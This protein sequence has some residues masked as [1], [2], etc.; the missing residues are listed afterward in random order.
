MWRSPVVAGIGLFVVLLAPM[1]SARAAM[2]DYILG[3]GDK[4]QIKLYEWRSTVG[5]V[6]EWSAL[7][8]DF[9]VGPAGGLSLPLIGDVQAAGLTTDQL[10]KSVAGEL[11]KAV[12]LA[13]PPTPSVQIV[14][15]RPFY[16]VG[17]VMRPGSYPFQPAMT[18]LQ[19]VSIA[20]GL[21]RPSDD[22]RYALTDVGDV[23]TLQAEYNRLVARRARLKAELDGNDKITFPS[24]FL[25]SAEDPEVSRLMQAEQAVFAARREA[26]HSQTD[27][28]NEELALFQKE[29]VS[30][31]AKFANADEELTMLKKELSNVSTMVT[32]GLD[33]APREFTL[34][35]SELEMES[36]RLDLDGAMLR[37]RQDV[38]RTETALADLR[39]KKRTETMA[40]QQQTEADLAKV[41]ATLGSKKAL[42]EDDG[43]IDSARGGASYAIV[44]VDSSGVQTIDASETTPVMPG[45]TVKVKRA[46]SGERSEGAVD[47]PGQPG[48]PMRPK[49][50]Q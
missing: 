50:S 23:R 6:H 42:L 15:F 29:I 8:G 38:A 5:E 49:S 46:S 2:A 16:I 1:H 4:V 33:I 7:S 31:G 3:A 37:A 20:G 28:L 26:L 34:R 43:G 11:Q 10:G 35:Q 21:F 32:R 45:D 22:L 44:R 12:G 48:T 40:E 13:K 17:G 18:V 47:P 41:S 25:Q 19:A 9:T 36:R 39:D 24:N 27:G 14:A 30:L